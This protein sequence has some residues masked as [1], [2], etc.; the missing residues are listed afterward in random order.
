MEP[1]RRILISNPFPILVERE[2]MLKLREIKRNT[3]VT[4]DDTI[5][6]LILQYEKSRVIK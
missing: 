2:T 6:W 3:D 4:Y 5:K 1:T